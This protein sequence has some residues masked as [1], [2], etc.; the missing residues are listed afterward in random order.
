M[1]INRSKKSTLI[2]AV[3]LL[4]V[5]GSCI[6]M[7]TRGF[8]LVGVVSDD[9]K[10]PKINHPASISCAINDQQFFTVSL[11]S[12]IAMDDQ[13][14]PSAGVAKHISLDLSGLLEVVTVGENTDLCRVLMRFSPGMKI[15]F[16]QGDQHHREQDLADTAN[17][18]RRGMMVVLAKHGHIVEFS[19]STNMDR[20]AE[21]L[22]RQLAAGFQFN[23]GN[24]LSSR[25]WS[26][27]EI[28]GSGIY[29]ADYHVDSEGDGYIK[30]TKSKGG[31]LTMN[32]SATNSAAPSVR[33]V[34]NGQV[35]FN[36]DDKTGW[37]RQIDGQE[38]A[39]VSVGEK[40]QQMVSVA[41][42]RYSFKFVN[43]QLLTRED[44]SALRSAVESP[45][46]T[47]QDSKRD[48]N[49]L[50]SYAKGRL[51]QTKLTDIQEEFR[52]IADPDKKST[53]NEERINY[54]RLVAYVRVNDEN[55]SVLRETLKGR[56]AKDLWLQQSLSVLA[57]VG[58][59]DC[60]TALVEEIMSRASDPAFA[61]NLL[62]LLSQPQDPSPLIE[63]ALRTL[64]KSSDSMVRSMAQLGLGT[65]SNHLKQSNQGRADLIAVDFVADFNRATT[66]DGK[67]IA[68]AVLGNT[69]SSRVI[70]LANPMLKDSEESNRIAAVNALRNVSA[71]AAS[72]AVLN[73]LSD[74][75]AQVRQNVVRVIAQQPASKVSCEMLAKH[76]Q[77]EPV[78]SV[79]SALVRQLGEYYQSMP[80]AKA[81]ID[82]LAKFDPDKEVRVLA[83][84]T[85]IMYSSR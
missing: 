22:L 52:K 50:K 49:Q 29:Q 37:P 33:G 60:Q 27:R 54:D 77:N 59:L 47:V 43:H 42:T 74:S 38:S 75:S 16:A 31:Y 14:G 9:G 18:L 30:A 6:F 15:D 73:M 24:S 39:S 79:R 56:D 13:G 40:P 11:H 21:Q 81:A 34:L 58:C 5:F 3:G 64:S 69:G 26:Q 1:S 8:S 17:D 66:L 25:N 48:F 35:K 65:V 46:A 84:N 71:P 53:A 4:A 51:G 36:L 68:L 78:A 62:S 41:T 20:F 67:L 55:L 63:D 44:V 7:F 28:D 32:G 82:R 19:S 80:M 72:E 70:D 83:E 2:I 45:A 57:Y 61:S 10:E 12:D 23:W 76:V 85:I